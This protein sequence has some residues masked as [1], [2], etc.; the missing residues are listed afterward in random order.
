MAA[1]TERML[2]SL[3]DDLQERFYT[4]ARPEPRL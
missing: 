1:R 4:S 3:Y 2:I